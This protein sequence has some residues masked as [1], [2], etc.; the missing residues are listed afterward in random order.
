MYITYPRTDSQIKNWR[1]VEQIKH[2]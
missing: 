1:A 2:Y